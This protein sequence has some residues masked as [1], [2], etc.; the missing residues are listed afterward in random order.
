M[1]YLYRPNTPFSRP[2]LRL[3]RQRY[4][5]KEST[6]AQWRH[7]VPQTWEKENIHKMKSMESL[8]KEVSD[9]WNLEQK[10]ADSEI[11]VVW[12]QVID[13]TI[14]AHAQPTGMRKGTLFV[15]VD[16]PAW[17]DEIVRFRR[18]EILK[19]LQASFSASEITRISFR[20]SG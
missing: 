14:Q 18:K 20:C 1:G 16:S 12:K 2:P 6:L 11:S 9:K 15:S 5:A 7:E 3:K 13:P 19:V 17:L 10:L 8:V 4:S